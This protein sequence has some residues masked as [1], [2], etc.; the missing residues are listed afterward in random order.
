M[1]YITTEWVSKLG[2]NPSHWRLHH[3][4]A[5][6]QAA[7]LHWPQCCQIT[8]HES[9][10]FWFYFYN[11]AGSDMSAIFI[12]V[13]GLN[14]EHLYTVWKDHQV[15]VYVKIWILI[16]MF[17]ISLSKLVAFNRP[18]RSLLNASHLLDGYYCP[19]VYHLD[20]WNPLCYCSKKDRERERESAELGIT[21]T[22]HTCFWFLQSQDWRIYF[23][24]LSCLWVMGNLTE[25]CMRGMA[26]VQASVGFSSCFGFK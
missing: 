12:Y 11:L 1:S 25:Q 16:S 4:M 13:N 9:R 23:S 22:P 2:G 15:I 17:Q 3:L 8:V 26:N 19:F 18:M 5:A 21:F 14:I 7:A 10:M 20:I 6:A 24:T